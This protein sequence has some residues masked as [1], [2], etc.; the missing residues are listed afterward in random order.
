MMEK[1]EG[2]CLCGNIRYSG[3][4]DILLT[5]VCHCIN[6]QKQSGAAFSTNFAV[7]E[8]SVKFSGNLSLYEDKGDSGKRVNRYFC[9]QCGSPLYSQSE[10]LEG[11]TILKAGTLDDSSWIKP[12]TAIYCDSAQ[13]WVD[14][15]NEIKN[16]PEMLES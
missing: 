9:N 11:L 7:A 8:N 10:M 12:D 6:C 2:G 5:A 13:A 14:L 4:T 15:G 1:I 16:F 3:E